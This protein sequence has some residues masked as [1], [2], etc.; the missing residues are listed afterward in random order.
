MSR[1]FLGRASQ[2]ASTQRFLHWPLA[3]PEVFESGG[4]DAIIGNPPWDMIRGDSG[5]GDARGRRQQQARDTGG[6][7]R[8]SGVYV[9]DGRAHANRYQ[10]F[11]E[12]SLQL[13]RP[14]GR[15]GLVLPAGIATDTGSAALRRHLFDHASVDSIT[16][17][18]NR[19]GIFP[20]HR[21]VRFALVSAT[22]GQRTERVACRFGLTRVDQLDDASDALNLSRELLMRLSGGDDLG[23]PELT[24]ARALRIV[25]HI[26]ARV[27]WLGDG[28][29][30]GVHFGRELNATDDRG[31][32]TTRTGRADARPIVEGKQIEPFHVDLGLSQLELRPDAVAGHRV[33]RRTRLAY[34]D[35]ASATNRLTLIAAMVP[36]DVVT[37]HT[38]FCLKTPLPLA[39]QQVLCGLLNSFVANYLIRLRVNTHVTATLMSRLP[40]PVVRPEDPAFDRLQLLTHILMKTADVEQTPE[41]AELQAIAAELY[42]L[43]AHRLRTRARDVPVDT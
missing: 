20:I 12:R 2:I 40:V 6:F 10:L 25:E 23:I 37:T 30:W 19:A 34:R 32:F 31:A 35:V 21:S 36:A 24:S 33:P 27:P 9:V 41:Y 18:D 22:A 42:G 5:I 7:F 13:L 39:H 11:V 29:G 38:L 17:L 14:G 3:F 4:F 8:Q 26:S 28:S 43:S 16:G 1:P 15:L